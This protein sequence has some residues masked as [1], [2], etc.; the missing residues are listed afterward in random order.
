MKF[1]LNYY[2]FRFRNVSTTGHFNVLE[3]F[4]KRLLL[5]GVIESYSYLNETL[6]DRVQINKDHLA[7]YNMIFMVLHED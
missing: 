3:T 6:N 2:K 1:R 5:S 4:L 7:Y